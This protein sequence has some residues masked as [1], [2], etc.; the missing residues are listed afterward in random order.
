MTTTESE[1]TAGNATATQI[2]PDQEHMQLQSSDHPGMV[3]VSALLTGNN[4]F[5]WSNAVKRAPTT[6]MKLDFIDG[7][8][9]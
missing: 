4:Y 8:A 6:K 5:A 2:A 1:S 7:T 9:V 3:M